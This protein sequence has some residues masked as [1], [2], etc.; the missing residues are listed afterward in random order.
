[1]KLRAS[2]TL[3]MRVSHPTPVVAILRPRSGTAQWLEHEKYSLEPWVPCSEFVDAF[4]NL[5]QRFIVAPEGIQVGV[6]MT[7]MVEDQLAVDE[8]AAW[9]P[10][11]ELPDEALAYLLPSRYCPSDKMEDKAWGIVGDQPSGYRQVEAIRAWIHEN[12]HYAYGTS[13]STTDACDTLADRTGVC[14]DFSHLG[15]S[16]CRALKIPARMVVGYLH[17]LDP[18]D[19]H[20]WFEA[21]VGNRWYTFDATQP[22]PKAGRI[23]LAYGRD[24][25]DVAF[26]SDYG[27]RP[28]EITAMKVEVSKV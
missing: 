18:M 12:I 5:C 24:A 14:R 21:Y 28:L 15:I 26:I 7:V 2:C 10:V 1:M 17:E 11:S 13:T 20:A 4:G 3:T 9:V 19:M 25:A 8:E 27:K 23:V 6:E 22:Q 16:L